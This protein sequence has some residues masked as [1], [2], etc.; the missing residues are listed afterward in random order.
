MIFAQP[1]LVTRNG[2]LDEAVCFS[3]VDAV[4]LP[5]KTLRELEVVTADLV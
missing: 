4:A 5:A 2:E 1:E 3:K